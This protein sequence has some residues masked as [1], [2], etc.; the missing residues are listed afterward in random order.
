M[1]SQQIAEALFWCVGV[2]GL[3]GLLV[4]AWL[5]WDDVRRIR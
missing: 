1:T 5:R 4:Y 3:S 2:P